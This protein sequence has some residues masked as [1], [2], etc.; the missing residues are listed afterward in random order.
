MIRSRLEM[1]KGRD[2]AG[3]AAP[4]RR[5]AR[6]SASW[7]L[8]CTF[9]SPMRSSRPERSSA[10]SGCA[11]TPDEHQHRAVAARLVEQV[12]E[13]AQARGVDREHV[14][15]AQDQH[16]RRA[17]DAAHGVLELA[18]R[19]E[20]ERAVDLEDLD[21]VR[22]V[23]R[24]VASGSARA[25]SSSRQRAPHRA[26]VA[27]RAMRRM[28]RNDGQHHAGLDRHGEVD[29]HGERERHQQH[30]HVAARAPEQAHEHAPL[31]HVPGHHEQD[32]GERAERD[33]AGPAAEE[34]HD[35]QQRQ[36]RA[37]CR[38]RACGRRS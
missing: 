31:A 3:L 18:R 13:R 19:A 2:Y 23:R 35:H 29:E 16:L 24:A 5:R 30:D 25:S 15:H 27:D 34:E 17:L 38:R 22:H 37:R 20:E 6:A 12:L 33:P 11:C 9:S 32:A 26:G 1:R 4:T 7:M 10:T 14:A 8:P 21:A 28:N 36:R